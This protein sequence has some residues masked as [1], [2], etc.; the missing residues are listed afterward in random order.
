MAYKT[1]REEPSAI[2]ASPESSVKPDHIKIIKGST[3]IL[4]IAPHACIRDGK[5]KDDE[6]TGPITEMVA[7]QIGC[8]AIINTHFHKPDSKKYPRGMGKGN[9][10]LNVIA[11]AEM[12]PGYLDA[13]RA[14]VEAPGK[15]TVIWIHGADNANAIEVASEATYDFPGDE[16]HAFIGYGQGGSRPKSGCKNLFTAK[17]ETVERFRDALISN[18]MNAVLTDKDA[19]NYRGRRTKGMNQWFLNQEYTLDQVESIQLEIRKAGFRDLHHNIEKTA[20]ILIEALSQEALVPVIPEE[21]VADEH[22]VDIAFNHLRG[23]FAKHIHEAMLQAGRYLV[24]TFY[25]TYEKARKKEKIRKQSFAKLEERL[26]NGTGDVPKKTWIYDAVKVAVDDHFFRKESKAFFLTYG[27]LGHSQKVLLTQVKDTN[28]KK[29]LVE[30]AV[31]TPQTVKQFRE[32]I[33]AIKKKKRKSKRKGGHSDWT[34]PENNVSFCSGCE[35]D[36]IYCYGR[37]FAA[38]RNQIA[39]NHWS[40]MKIREHHVTKKRT[41]HAGLIGFPSTH[42]ILPSNLDA[43]LLVLGKLLRAG[44]KVLIMSKPRLDCI[45]R[46]CSACE[47]FKDTI[48]FRFTIGAMD[49]D[50]LGF[51]EPNAPTYEERKECLAYARNQGFQTSVSMEPMLD[52]ENLDALIKALRP[53]VSDKI[54]LGTMEY[55]GWIGTRIKADS[56]GEL[57]RL[58]QGQT[59][60]KLVSIF[61]RYEDDPMIEWKTVA[62]KIIEAHKQQERKP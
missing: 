8:S 59:P 38:N 53:L 36:C 48:L 34:K 18:R 39:P 44:N 62:L 3:D 10:D 17:P 40:K 7:H 51:W 25:G 41:L 42:D 14:V 24:R 2:M 21:T 35:N 31:E 1:R 50:I 56:K 5:P 47:F 9:L 61:N 46:L 37:Y 60:D 13:I 54:W 30:K 11:D 23:I 26:N 55:L 22:L 32:S 29:E 6:N 43:T 27:K 45:K 57:E 58:E 16:I 15:T 12:V 4:L 28:Q 49:D 33:Q 20:G 19:V 52:T